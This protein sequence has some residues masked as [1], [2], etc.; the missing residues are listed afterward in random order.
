M[1]RNILEYLETSARSYP[2]KTAFSDDAA[3]LSFKETLDLSKRVGSA[4]AVFGEDRLPVAV[5]MDKTP[6][7]LTAFF[8]AVY[9]GRSYSP[10]DAQMPPRRVEQILG[11][12][13]TDYLIVDRTTEKNVDQLDY[14]GRVLLFED[15]IRTPVDESLLTGIRKKAIDTDP[16]YIIFTSGSTGVPKGVVLSHRAV[17]DLTEWLSDTF[18]FSEETVFGNQTPFYFDASVKDIYSTLRNGSACRIIP[19]Q[20]F[21]FP[22][23]LFG[24]LNEKKINT[25]LWATSALC[26]TEGDGPFETDLPKSL[27]TIVFAGEVM[28]VR[29]LNLWRKWL[30]DATYVN[31]YGP[32]EAAVD[33][34]FYVVDREF[35]ENESLPIGRPC[36]NMEILILNGDKPVE[37]NEVGEICIRGTALAN[38]YYRDPEKTAEVFVQNPL[39]T[40][41][42]ELIYRTGD[43]GWYNDR[44]EI[45]FAS[46][47]DG[48]IKHRGYR[49]ELGEV[50]TAIAG[51]PGVL[52]CCC[53]FDQAADKIVCVYT[54]TAERKEILLLASQSLPKYMWPNT[55]VRLDALPMTLNGKIDR[56]RLKEEYIHE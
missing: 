1:I 12:L 16:L 54:G 28:P 34:A 9:S 11:T 52:R 33:A 53:L 6:F 41:Y 55:F 49:I 18:G 39:N 26:I 3:E 19:R 22:K 44:G 50:E 24:Y 30:P 35:G 42:P 15:L 47:K 43:M 48:Q 46:R 20:L 29:F 38:G 51:V 25:I 23:K 8:G 17:I 10:I 45:M 56:V 13:K 5:Y 32:T 4:L 37:G 21:A 27:K 36:Q 14:K 40:A 2:D 31:L 7:A